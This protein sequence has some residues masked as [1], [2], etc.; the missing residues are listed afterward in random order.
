MAIINLDFVVFSF[1]FI[2]F[3]N[4]SYYTVRTAV[5]KPVCSTAVQKNSLQYSCTQN[6]FTEQ[7]YTIQLSV[8]FKFLKLVVSK[9]S[10]SLG[11]NEYFLN[12]SFTKLDLSSF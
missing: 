3:E 5:Q 1:R 2:E 10:S 7:M 8:Q 9:V 6:Q 12:L 4:G 11:S